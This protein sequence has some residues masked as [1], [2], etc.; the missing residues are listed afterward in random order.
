MIQIEVNLCESL[1]IGTENRLQNVIEYLS[2]SDLKIVTVTPN[3]P[4]STELNIFLSKNIL[5][6]N[7]VSL[8]LDLSS[9]KTFE[10][11]WEVLG[12]RIIYRKMTSGQITREV[13]KKIR[14]ATKHPLK[15]GK[16]LMLKGVSV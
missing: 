6:Y 3:N 2:E 8:S 12:S 1:Y 14:I 9:T 5:E 16:N 15:S 7:N 11:Y 13:T 4:E 10:R